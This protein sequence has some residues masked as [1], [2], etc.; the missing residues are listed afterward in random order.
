[1]IEFVSPRGGSFEASPEPI[2]AQLASFLRGPDAA[3]GVIVNHCEQP[4]PTILLGMRHRTA[5]S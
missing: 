1:M 2:A 3:H 4:R 5:L